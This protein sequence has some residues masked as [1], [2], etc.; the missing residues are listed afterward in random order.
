M[1]K[2]GKDNSVKQVEIV[3][4]QI[5]QNG[6]EKHLYKMDYV[7]KKLTHMVVLEE[8]EGDAAL[9]HFDKVIKG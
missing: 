8:L 9:K 5:G 1:S 4:M 6:V 3:S 2:R 7:S